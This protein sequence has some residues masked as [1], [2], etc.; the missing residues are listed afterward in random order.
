MVSMRCVAATKRSRGST[1]AAALAAC[2]GLAACTKEAWLDTTPA[3]FV[4]APILAPADASAPATLALGDAAARA[5]IRPLPDEP[6]PPP[7]TVNCTR[8]TTCHEEE[9]VTPPFAYPAPF[10]RCTETYDR[11]GP[12]ARFSVAETL[13]ARRSDPAACCYVEFRN[14]VVPLSPR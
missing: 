9:D 7:H 1:S 2:L 8:E 5:G 6:P 13:A 4:A 14:C 12:A 3:G 11:A 10:E